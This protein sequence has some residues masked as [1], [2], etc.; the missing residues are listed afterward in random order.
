L[1]S[2]QDQPN[3]FAQ[4]SSFTVISQPIQQSIMEDEVNPIPPF[5]LSD[6]DA[7]PSERDP[8]EVFCEGKPSGSIIS[9]PL[10]FQKTGK[11]RQCT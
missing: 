8:L 6:I 5:S 7:S 2:N 3:N 4:N 10:Y 11:E 1:F 9:N